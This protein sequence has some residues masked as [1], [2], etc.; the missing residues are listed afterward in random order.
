MRR[1]VPTAYISNTSR[2]I[3]MKFVGVVDNH[4]L[5]KLIWFNWHMTSS[6][7]HIDVITVKVMRYM[8]IT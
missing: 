3:E 2:K 8:Y 5:I 7:F 6:I 1:K 4:K